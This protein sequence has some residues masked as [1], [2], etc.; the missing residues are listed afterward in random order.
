MEEQKEVDFEYSPYFVDIESTKKILGQMVNCICQ[1]KVDKALGTGF[2]CKIPDRNKNTMNCLLTANHV[3]NE[4]YYDK[5]NKIII[6]MNDEEQYKSI[7]LGI[8][9]NVCF[10][11]KKDVTIIELVKEDKIEHFL[12]LEEDKK[13]SRNEEILNNS[14]R[15]KSI[16]IPQYPKHKK[17]S[18][19]YGI[20]QKKDNLKILHTCV[21]D[22]GS[23][24]SPILDLDS[25]KVIGMHKGSNI[26]TNGNINIGIFFNFLS[27]I[28]FKPKQNKNKVNEINLE[29][30][31]TPHNNEESWFYI[32]NEIINNN[33]KV[34]EALKFKKSEK[35][36][37]DIAKSIIN[38]IK[39]LKKI[40][41]I[42]YGCKENAI[43][44]TIEAMLII[45]T[46][47]R[48]IR[49]DPI[50]F[51]EI[52]KK[53]KDRINKGLNIMNKTEKKENLRIIN[54]YIS[55]YIFLFDEKKGNDKLL[56]ILNGFLYME[57]LGKMFVDD[58][59]SYES[60]EEIDNAFNS[61]YNEFLKN[62]KKKNWEIIKYYDFI[63]DNV[64]FGDSDKGGKDGNNE[65]E[66][67]DWEDKL[68]NY[69]RHDC[70]IYFIDLGIICPIKY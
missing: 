60:Q 55:N 44:D 21:T 64:N 33:D 59:F 6:S 10:D 50:F 61:A 34:K 26:L 14:Y 57:T 19:S 56:S 22:N 8:K 48:D 54:E 65:L 41:K 49:S 38:E 4:E 45:L 62:L 52:E 23:S 68:K 3:L 30:N 7:D 28:D 51:N 25:L 31:I 5:T 29:K 15:A 27:N 17:A 47:V 12:E 24:G 20:I 67:E 9:R 1:L 11:E 2:F 66:N 42:F 40:F 39:T 37:D 63:K 13:L 32:F 69:F 58:I 46:G 70:K 35:E 18:V 16:Y 43:H 53:I 36:I